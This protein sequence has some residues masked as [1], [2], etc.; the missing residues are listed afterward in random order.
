MILYA[1]V[2]PIDR[3]QLSAQDFYQEMMTSM[4]TLTLR[5]HA[6]TQKL[7]SAWGKFSITPG[8]SMPMAGY[9][10]RDGFESVH[11]SLY[12]RVIGL[13]NGSVSCYLISAD[14]LLFPPAVKQTIYKK[15]SEE[16][17]TK[18]FLYF[19]A[20]HTHNG[21]GGWNSSVAGNFIL[22]DYDESWVTRTTESL[23]EE[24]KR[25]DKSMKSATLS[26]WEADALEYAENRLVNGGPHDG[27]L[28]GIKFETSDSATAHLITFSAHA[29]SISKKS[30]ALSGDYPG[31]LVS[32]LREKNNSF[33]IFMAG[34]VGSHR[35]T[36]LPETEFEL[37][38][39]AGE[40]LAQKI[41][42]ASYEATIDS[43]QIRAAHI[44]IKFGPSQLRIAKN[45]RLRDWVFSSSFNPLEGE[46]TYL[47][48]G[49]IVLIGTPCDFSGEL[50]V[51]RKLNELARSQ[52]KHLMITSFNGDYVGYIT[53]DSH[54]EQIEKEEVRSM[55]WVGPYY[56][57]YFTQM[58]SSLLKK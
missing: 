6:P 26:Y 21:I 19:S 24:I 39:K 45:W 10:L 34:M 27:L 37:V 25:I 56:G 15:I 3:T 16:F 51:T 50:F 38:A 49:N 41:S 44:P 2:G 29:T 52:N 12:V 30:N 47:Q 31:S 8:Y 53:E 55:N 9:T 18:P 40:M 4:D 20:T 5:T 54:Y 58:I 33:G 17:S 23:I 43:L 14:L 28:R 22:G 35:L 48:L 11:D 13:S 32:Q 42:G 7:K 46:L 1:M 57:D 36:G